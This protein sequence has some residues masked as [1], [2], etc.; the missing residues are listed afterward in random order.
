MCKYRGCM[1]CFAR[2]SEFKL[3]CM[4]F[5]GVIIRQLS[6]RLR[7][8]AKPFS[9]N[10]EKTFSVNKEMNQVSKY[11]DKKFSYRNILGLQC[12]LPIAFFFLELNKT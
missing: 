12:I 1:P 10:N 5:N 8:A 6:T 4:K 2:L 7:Q 3:Y 11:A 9:Y